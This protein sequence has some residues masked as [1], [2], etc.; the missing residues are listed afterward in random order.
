MNS[1]VVRLKSR[2]NLKIYSLNRVNQIISCGNLA[3]IGTNADNNLKIL[4]R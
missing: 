2:R 3:L 1:L 4:S